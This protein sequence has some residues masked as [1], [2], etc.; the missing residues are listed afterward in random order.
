M[1]LFLRTRWHRISTVAVAAIL[2]T[3]CGKGQQATTP[4]ATADT[5]AVPPVAIVNGSPI[6]RADYDAFLKNLLQGKPAADVTPEQK[7]QVLDELITM[8]LVS[9]QA[10]KDGLEKDPDVAANLEVVRMRILS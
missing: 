9:A 5:T 2:L 8:K 4:A 6:P 10:D 7:S 1:T 3:A